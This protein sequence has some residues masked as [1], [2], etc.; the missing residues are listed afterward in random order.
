MLLV[1]ILFFLMGTTI[2]AAG[3]AS[4]RR[5]D[6]GEWV[7]HTGEVLGRIERTRARLYAAK[8]SVEGRESRPKEE[9][10]RRM[11]SSLNEAARE[12]DALERLTEK[13]A[14]HRGHVA[15]L[16]RHLG[17]YSN[18]ARGIGRAPAP[19]DPDPSQAFEKT[20]NGLDAMQE[21]EGRLLALRKAAW[22]RSVILSDSTLVASAGTMTI[23]IA[24]LVALVRREEAARRREGRAVHER[25]G[26]LRDLSLHLPVAAVHVS[27]GLV[28]MNEATQRLTGF[29][30]DEIRTVD[31]WFRLTRREDAAMARRVYEEEQA[32]GFVHTSLRRI[33]T[34]DGRERYL[35][36]AGY[37][38]GRG[39]VWIFHDVTQETVSRRELEEA[40]G[41]L[42]ALATTDALTGLT[43]RR[44][45][46]ARFEGAFAHS[47][48]SESPLSALMLDI[49]HFKSVN[50]RYG[51][52]VG[53]AALREVARVLAWA[54]REGDV[55]ARYGGEEFAMILPGLG[56]GDALAVAERIRQAVEEVAFNHGRTTLSVGV[57][58][59]TPSIESASCL[60]RKA[61]EALYAAKRDGRNRVRDAD[62]KGCAEWKTKSFLL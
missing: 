41:A 16:K 59:R 3:W 51:H 8:I 20:L 54:T 47:V 24:S 7:R 32:N 39:E 6:Q 44:A 53:D 28:R 5:K 11:E 27:E 14:A 33:W 12:I 48:A 35:E 23:A 13:N 38:E 37:S 29:G 55:A 56:E 10:R 57:A 17:I 34:K 49:D 46:D 21:A 9:R 1:G 61:D 26:Q 30:N 19:G 22:A 4:S 15:N 36:F 18:A 52:D 43:N 50:D 42:S 60:M 2:A 58:T 40:N 31:D 45:F 25:M 62:G